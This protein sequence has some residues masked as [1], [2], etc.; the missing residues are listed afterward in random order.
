MKIVE[1]TD[2]HHAWSESEIEQFL[3]YWQVGTMQHTAMLCLWTTGLRASDVIKL[4]ETEVTD[5]VV[6]CAITKTKRGK[7]KY[8]K[9]KVEPELRAALDASKVTNIRQTFV[10][11]AY[12]QPFSSGKSFSNWFG[13]AVRKAGLPSCCTPHGVR[14]ALAQKWLIVV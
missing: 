3:D 6:Q 14:K 12:G 1:E 9:F 8:L 2:G 7:N 13:K 4:S 11:T 5:E 10:G